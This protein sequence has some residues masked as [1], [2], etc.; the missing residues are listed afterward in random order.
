VE[1][2]ARRPSHELTGISI[3]NTREEI[4]GAL[5]P[6]HAKADYT[7]LNFFQSGLLSMPQMLPGYL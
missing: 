3:G 1:R 4:L 5:T 7:D 2:E 6:H